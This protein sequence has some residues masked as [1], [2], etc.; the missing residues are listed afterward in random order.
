MILD[1]LN[2]AAARG[3]QFLAP[4]VL[5]SFL[6]LSIPACSGTDDESLSSVEIEAIK[7]ASHVYGTAWLSNDP[8][9]VMAT[10]TNDAVIV[11]SGMSPIQGEEA[12]RAFWWPEDSPPTHVTEFSSTEEEAGGYG[13]FGFVRGTFTLRFQYDG[14][15]FSSGGTYLSLMRCLPDGSWR[16]SHRMWSDG[17]RE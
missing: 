12:I 3:V 7:A 1:R 16:I 11:P 4:M 17:P 13:G 10:L 2:D 5:A 6:M 14:G 8:E 15:D 9:A